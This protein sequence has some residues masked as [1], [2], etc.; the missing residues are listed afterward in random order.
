MT[1]KEARDLLSR[2]IAAAL[3]AEQDGTATLLDRS[4]IVLALDDFEAAIRQEE[5]HAATKA[6][7]NADWY[8]CEVRQYRRRLNALE[9]ALDAEAVVS[10]FEQAI[11]GNERLKE[12]E[13]RRRED[14]AKGL[15]SSR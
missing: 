10:D 8:M 15:R 7:Q 11:R 4:A 1:P 5:K 12:A 6:Y 3:N 9:S 13:R 14:A 2:Q